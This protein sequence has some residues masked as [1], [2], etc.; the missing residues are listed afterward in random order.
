MTAKP[1]GV[2]SRT[3]APNSQ[4]GSGYLHIVQ[5]SHWGMHGAKD[6]GR[7]GTHDA[8]PELSVPSSSL[9]NSYPI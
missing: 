5:P 3:R 6:P 1:Q 9:E 2:I 8:V 4:L 7:A